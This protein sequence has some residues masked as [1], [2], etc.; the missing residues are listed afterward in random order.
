METKITKEIIESLYVNKCINHKDIAKQLNVSDCGVRKAIRKY[1]F[2][3]KRNKSGPPIIDL[4]GQT[5]GGYKV[6]K[7][8]GVD[9]FSRR[10][11]TCGCLKCGKEINITG[12]E[13]SGTYRTERKSC[14]RCRRVFYGKL[15]NRYLLHLQ[16]RARKKK[17]EW[18][19]KGEYLW[20]VYEKQNGRCAYTGRNIVFSED[21]RN[22][23][24][25][26]TA[27]LDRIDSGKG[28]IKGNVQ[29]LHKDVNA[30]KWNYSN[31]NFLKLCKEVVDYRKNN[32]KNT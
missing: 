9:K 17:I 32:D 19:V 26:Q 8:H 5:V 27:S 18:N 25:D 2:T 24:K 4:I 14:M 15:H 28:Y 10:M 20:D 1:G 13:L 7:F 3:V 29:W 31:E 23:W 21:Y 11:W 16:T 30:M 12:N 22:K 6:L